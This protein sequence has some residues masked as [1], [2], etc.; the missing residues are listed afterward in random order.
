MFATLFIKQHSLQNINQY[1]VNLIISLGE[2]IFLVTSAL[3]RDIQF[4]F[5]SGKVLL[6]IPMASINF[7]FR[8]KE[9][10]NFCKSIQNF[11]NIIFFMINEISLF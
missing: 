8:I 6:I 11:V 1:R 3:L 5:L 10:S 2:N 4:F 9:K 7:C